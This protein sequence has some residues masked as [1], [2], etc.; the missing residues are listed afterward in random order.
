MGHISK[1]DGQVSSEEIDLAN[2][3][4][5]WMELDADKRK[6]AREI[7][8]NGRD[9]SLALDEVLDQ[10]RQECNDSGLIESFLH[11]QI[12]AANADGELHPRERALLEHIQHRLGLPSGTVDSILEAEFGD[13]SS[14]DWAYETLELKEGRSKEDIERAYRRMTNSYHPDKL[15]SKG[16]PEEMMRFATEKTRKIK[17][18]YEHL[19]Q[20]RNIH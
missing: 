17:A 12:D 20:V 11:I 1:A 10:L 8:A 6:F 15:A 5:E 4:M 7:F 18:A 13:H 14:D 16:L 3:V 2:S 9:S 19:R